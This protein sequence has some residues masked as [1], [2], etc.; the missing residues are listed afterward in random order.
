MNSEIAILMAAGL[1][2]RMAPLTEKTPK[3]LVKVFGKPMIETVIDGLE[4]R[5]VNHIYVVVGYMK[6]QFTFLAEKYKNLSLIEN[7]EYLT[8]NNIS[9]IRAAAHVMGRDD[10]FICEADLCVSDPS[11]F[12]AE[13]DHSCYYG[14]MV[15]GHSDDWVLEQDESGRIVRVG[16]GGDDC[17]NMCGVAYFKASDAKKIADAINEAYT[18]PGTYETLFWDDIVDRQLENIDLV[19]HPVENDQIVEIDSVKELE[20]V[21]PNYKEYN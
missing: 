5:G 12:L 13:L 15:K 11:I 3:P 16:K 10:C 7:T 2:T 1:G 21:D 6:E 19:V 4:K 17:Y 14:K 9:S 18:H 20:A 8:V